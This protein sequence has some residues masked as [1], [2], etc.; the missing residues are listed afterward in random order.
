M[1]ATCVKIFAIK[2][3]GSINICYQENE[4][5]FFFFW[6]EDPLSLRKMKETQACNFM[7]N[8]QEKLF[9]LDWNKSETRESR[10]I[11]NMKKKIHTMPHKMWK[12]YIKKIKNQMLDLPLGEYI[13]R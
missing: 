11:V 9:R 6:I 7:K 3:H 13:L 4:R 5:S 12:R 10:L 8:Y 1:N 2:K